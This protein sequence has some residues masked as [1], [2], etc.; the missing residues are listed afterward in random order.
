MK[1]LI[2]TADDYGMSPAV[3]RA[4]EEGV[5]AGLI[6]ATNVMM[7]MP[8]CGDAFHLSGKKASVGLHWVLTC[9]RPLLSAEQVPSLTA[10]NGEFYPL[11]EFR[12]RYRRGLISQ[13]EISRELTAQYEAFKALLGQ[14]EYWNTHQHVHVARG[15]YPLFLSVSERLGIMQMR[16]NQ[17]I[18]VPGSGRGGNRPLKWR[19]LE[20]V[21]NGVLGYWQG[22]AYRRG[23]AFP[24]G[25]I[26]ALSREDAE[27]PQY[28]F[29]HIRWNRKETAEY[30][31]HPAAAYD[32][33]YFGE[34][35]ERR[36]KE[37][38]IFTAEQTHR[39]LADAGIELVS[40]RALSSCAR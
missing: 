21:K 23:V 10:R 11:S 17:R 28:L 36:M 15:L 14:P 19:M 24:D 33:P 26:V 34:L 37:Y 6:T 2:V 27:N 13:A 40:F 8:F 39:I 9:G 35:I 18:Y 25:L 12:K 31:I 4:I 32:S 1:K 5:A 7:N 3:N 20:P 16:N 38:R 29:H 30:M 22:Q